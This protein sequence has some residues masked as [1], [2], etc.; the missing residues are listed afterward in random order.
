MPVITHGSFELLGAAA[1]L[2]TGSCRRDGN[3][4]AEL[5]EGLRS[6]CETQQKECGEAGENR[7]PGCTMEFRGHERTPSM[8]EIV[9]PRHM[10][11][12]RETTLGLVGSKL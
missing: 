2:D 5:R 10:D 9:D 4:D 1:R 7:P 11:V 8:K 3:C 12:D 6:E